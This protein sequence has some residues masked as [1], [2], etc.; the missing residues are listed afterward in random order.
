MCSALLPP[1]GPVRPSTRMN[2]RS[3]PKPR[4]SGT[5]SSCPYIDMIDWVPP[6]S[7]QRASSDSAPSARPQRM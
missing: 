3:M 6:S 7:C 5:R 1:E 4:T 2:L